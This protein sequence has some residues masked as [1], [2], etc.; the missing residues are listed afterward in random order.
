[1]TE[2][3]QPYRPPTWL[4]AALLLSGVSG[5]TLL[6]LAIVVPFVLGFLG[7]YL[8]GLAIEAVLLVLLV[9]DHLI[10]RRLIRIDREHRASW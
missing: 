4:R 7:L 5:L 2:P 3:N 1:M 8:L 9:A 6:A 10:G